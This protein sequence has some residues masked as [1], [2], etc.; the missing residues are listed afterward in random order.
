MDNRF[1]HEN[2]FEA[3]DT[4]DAM[5]FSGCP[6][7]NEIEALEEYIKRWGN[8]IEECKKFNEEEEF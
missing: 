1:R 5:L 4:I 3:V 2:D 7:D 6:T 8:Q